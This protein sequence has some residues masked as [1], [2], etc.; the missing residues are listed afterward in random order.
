VK[1]EEFFQIDQLEQQR[2]QAGKSYL[3]F[4]RVRR[5]APDLV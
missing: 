4:L 5:W 3:E 2:A 1:E